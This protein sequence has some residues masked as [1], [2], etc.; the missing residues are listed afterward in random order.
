MS[1][2]YKSLKPPK[3]KFLHDVALTE[4]HPTNQENICQTFFILATF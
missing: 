2:I 1:Y 4:K 3:D